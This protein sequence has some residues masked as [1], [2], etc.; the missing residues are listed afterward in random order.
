MGFHFLEII[1]AVS[2]VSHRVNVKGILSHADCVVLGLSHGSM[3]F[4]K[5]S[6]TILFYSLLELLDISLRLLLVPFFVTSSSLLFIIQLELDSFV[7]ALTYGEDLSSP[8]PVQFTLTLVRLLIENAA[9]TNFLANDSSWLESIGE[10]DI[11]VHGPHINV[12]DQGLR[13]YGRTLDH[14]GS[15]FSLNL[16][17]D[18]MVVRDLGLVLMT[19][20]H[21]QGKVHN[22]FCLV[23]EHL[24]GFFFELKLN[25]DITP[26][27]TLL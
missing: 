14:Q 24:I 16:L 23:D 13:R 4:F 10:D 12:V 21:K 2:K 19:R 8:L 18:L 15:Q 9:G 20:L 1:S 25:G 17:L 27:N 6:L 11:R 5:V 26:I 3:N 22:R 7:V